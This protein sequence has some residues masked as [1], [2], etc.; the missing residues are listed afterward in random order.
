[1]NSFVVCK[2]MKR[3]S[4]KVMKTSVL[5]RSGLKRSRADKYRALKPKLQRVVGGGAARG[6]TLLAKAGKR[7]DDFFFFCE[8]PDD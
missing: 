6:E 2:V 1:M 3:T 5:R 7:P 8:C 4:T